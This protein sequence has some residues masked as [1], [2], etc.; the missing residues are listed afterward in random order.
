MRYPL[1]LAQYDGEP[2]DYPTKWPAQLLAKDGTFPMRCVIEVLTPPR[3]VLEIPTDVPADMD[4]PEL[5][6]YVELMSAQ[7]NQD[8]VHLQHT[9]S[10]FIAAVYYYA[11]EPSHMTQQQAST[12]HHTVRTTAAAATL[13]SHAVASKC[14]TVIPCCPGPVND[15]LGGC[16]VREEVHLMMTTEVQERSR[17][18]ADNISFDK[19]YF[20]NEYCYRNRGAYNLIGAMFPEHFLRSIQGDHDN[21]RL[22]RRPDGQRLSTLQEDIRDHGQVFCLPLTQDTL[23]A[24]HV[25]VSWRPTAETEPPSNLTRAMQ[26][27]HALANCCYGLLRGPEIQPVLPLSRSFAGRVQRGPT[28]QQSQAIQAYKAWAE[29]TESELTKLREA[30]RSEAQNG[31]TSRWA[32]DVLGARTGTMAHS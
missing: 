15:H 32:M 8:V 2:E 30:M 18:H 4:D 11:C 12:R 24:I 17:K 26:E 20:D 28:P 7:P 5:R 6:T 10:I 23:R 29:W 14:G 21:S 16:H 25:C 9:E 13:L 19:L 27:V 31:G 22:T 3:C 1:R